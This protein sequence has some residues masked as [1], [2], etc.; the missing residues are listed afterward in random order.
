MLFL[1]GDLSDWGYTAG[2]VKYYSV[3]DLM[4]GS[5]SAR[6]TVMTVSPWDGTGSHCTFSTP[7]EMAQLAVYNLSFPSMDPDTS[8]AYYDGTYLV[9]FGGASSWPALL[10]AYLRILKFP[11]TVGDTWP[12]LDTCHTFPGERFIIGDEDVDGLLD[13]LYYDTS[14]ATTTY[15]NGDT[16]EVYIYPM[17][18]VQRLTM[19]G[20][21]G[22]TFYCCNRFFYH[23][24]MRFRYVRG[25][26]MV[27]LNIDTLLIYNTYTLIDTLTGD[28]LP[29]PVYLVGRY[30]DYQLWE[31]VPTAVAERPAGFPKLTLNRGGLLKVEGDVSIY[32]HDGRL[33]VHLKSGGTVR[34]KPGIYFLRS[35]G[36]VVKVIVR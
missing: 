17:K 33:V 3:Q 36:R 31:Y 23:Y 14:Y 6:E 28:T 19:S 15:L 27:Q 32:S 5:F 13:T 4:S 8:Y 12:A 18:I 2:A 30:V 20:Y 29:V 22:D 16:V 24:Y 9:D 34:L 25:V 26:G 35:R 1:L 7:V 11:L 21:L 10:G